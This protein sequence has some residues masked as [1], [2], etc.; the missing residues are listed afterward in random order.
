MSGLTRQ[1]MKRDEVRE[2]MEVAMEWIADNVRLILGILGGIAAAIAITV[3]VLSML[4]SRAEASQDELANALRLFA[5]PINETAADPENPT[6]PSFASNAERVAA[7]KTA[8]E[9]VRSDGGEAARIATIYLGNMAA[10]AADLGE[11]RELWS[12]ALE[13][14]TDSALAAS[15]RLNLLSLDRQEGKHSDIIESLEAQLASSTPS[16]PGDVVLFELGRALEATGAVE[17][18]KDRYQQL[19]DEY[20]SS[21][22]GTEARSR[23]ADAS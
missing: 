1:E 4:R 22:F 14:L 19:L 21:Q 13:G 7:A 16:L 5:A 11:A 9:D 23:V 15:V 18:A 10:D 3:G 2:W 6:T 12:E 20:P 8:F 17:Q